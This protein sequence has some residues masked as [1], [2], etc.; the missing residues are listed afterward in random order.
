MLPDKIERV[1][2][3]EWSPDGKYLFIGQE[4]AV[5][6]RSDKIWRHTVGSDRSD[7]VYEEKD[8]LFDVGIGRS[9]DR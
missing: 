5:S 1:T 7:L 4:D 2:S 6:K 9:R 3:A 8:V